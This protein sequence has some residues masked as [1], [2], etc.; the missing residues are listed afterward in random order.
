M[1]S[2]DVVLG[3]IAV[4]AVVVIVVVLIAEWLQCN[5]AL[6]IGDDIINHDLKY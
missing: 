1:Y 4:D 3:C 6:T 2:V 5:S